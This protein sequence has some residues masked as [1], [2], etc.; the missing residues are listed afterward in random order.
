[1]HRESQVS[2]D[3]LHISCKISPSHLVY[4]PPIFRYSRPI[5]HLSLGCAYIVIPSVRYVT[6][7][8]LWLW[9]ECAS[10]LNQT[11]AHTLPSRQGQDP[12]CS[13]A[14]VFIFGLC[15]DKLDKGVRDYAVL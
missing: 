6:I 12:K 10:L 8:R 13:A 1:M 5:D 11:W 7:V 3:L 14:P 2:I 15:V 9:C 4:P